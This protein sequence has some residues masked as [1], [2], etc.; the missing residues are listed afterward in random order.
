VAAV[1]QPGR[2]L[3]G[4]PAASLTPAKLLEGRAR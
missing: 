2:R 3:S 1:S 4:A